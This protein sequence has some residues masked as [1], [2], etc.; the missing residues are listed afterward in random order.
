MS[1]VAFI[2]SSHGSNL[3]MALL[4]AGPG[5]YV[6]LERFS[7]HFPTIGSLT[8]VFLDIRSSCSRRHTFLAKRARFN[9]SRAFISS[10]AI[11]SRVQAILFLIG[12]E[13]GLTGVVARIIAAA[14]SG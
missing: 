8:G 7:F 6:D 1:I 3:F 9:E 13:S 14:T 10:K 12:D 5:L 11:S 2:P 4:G